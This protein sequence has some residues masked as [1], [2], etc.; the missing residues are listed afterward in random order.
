MTIMVSEY[1]CGLF[2]KVQNAIA[3][4]DQDTRASIAAAV[5]V[6]ETL[7]QNLYHWIMR[8]YDYIRLEILSMKQFT[9]EI[10]FT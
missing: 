2:I 6:V 1:N 5:V 10:R 4:E 3:C 7:K 9:E 8:T